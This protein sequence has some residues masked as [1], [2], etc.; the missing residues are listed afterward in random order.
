M[1]FIIHQ[2]LPLC[3]P[4]NC[5]VLFLFNVP[6]DSRIFY[7]VFSC[8]PPPWIFVTCLILFLEQPFSLSA[9]LASLW[10][11]FFLG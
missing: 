3:V 8:L 2:S 7:A 11:S 9:D 5:P 1:H 4:A 6:V 10:L